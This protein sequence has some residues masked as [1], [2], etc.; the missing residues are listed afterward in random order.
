MRSNGRAKQV[1]GRGSAQRGVSTGRNDRVHE[2]PLRLCA[3]VLGA[4][5]AEQG[6][7]EI[8]SVGVVSR[9]QPVAVARSVKQ[10][11]DGARYLIASI[12]GWKLP[13]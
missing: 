9:A 3:Q 7:E 8:E 13:C 4:G 10:S 5:G 12:V 6:D 11:A 2:R 1:P